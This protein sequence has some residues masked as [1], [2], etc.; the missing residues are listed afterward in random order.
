S[1]PNGRTGISDVK[2]NEQDKEK[3]VK[4]DLSASVNNDKII[5]DDSNC[6]RTDILTENSSAGETQV[7]HDVTSTE[8]PTAT[9]TATHTVD[10]AVSTADVDSKESATMSNTPKNLNE[11]APSPM[12]CDVAKSGTDELPE[13]ECDGSDDADKPTTEA[14]GESK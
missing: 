8:V 9:D 5:S 1:L 3:P 12:P 2:T 7:V 6:T 10:N 11:S 13:V 14:T 4:E